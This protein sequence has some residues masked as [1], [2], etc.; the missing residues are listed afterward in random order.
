[1]NFTKNLISKWTE[2]RFGPL[3]AS[4]AA[5]AKPYPKL[6][7]YGGLA[8]LDGGVQGHLLSDIL[9]STAKGTTFGLTKMN[10]HSKLLYLRACLGGVAAKREEGGETST[11]YDRGHAMAL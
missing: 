8:H 11:A 3:R 1:M 10:E 2:S 6:G 4:H 5:T 9:G 7:Y